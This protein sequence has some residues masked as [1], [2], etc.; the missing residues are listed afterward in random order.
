MD[1]ILRSQMNQLSKLDDNDLNKVIN[2]LGKMF[3]CH[4]HVY[5]S[6]T[7]KTRYLET[8][9]TEIEKIT[10]SYSLTQSVEKSN[11]I[12]QKI[13]LE[14]PS[15]FDYVLNKFKKFQILNI[16]NRKN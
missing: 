9:S 7:D 8:V 13:K 3:D 11:I 6:G 5:Q 14:E 2:E 4:F 1:D 12:I 15:L 10:K 16:S